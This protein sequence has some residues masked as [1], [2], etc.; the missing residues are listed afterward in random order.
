M[1]LSCRLGEQDST[2]KRGLVFYCL[3]ATRMTMEALEL[4]AFGRRATMKGEA[5]ATVGWAVPAYVRGRGVALAPVVA[6][7]S[8]DALRMSWRAW[9]LTWP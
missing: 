6:V 3:K 7:A 9:G 1:A 4:G 8:V 2:R 5:A